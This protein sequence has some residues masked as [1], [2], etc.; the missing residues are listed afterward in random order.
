MNLRAILNLIM[1]LPLTTYA[2]D[3]GEKVVFKVPLNER[4]IIVTPDGYFPNQISIH[5][6]EKLR[7]YL[8][9]TLNTPTCL[10]IPQKN[11]FMGVAIKEVKET[12]VEFKEAG[13]Y[14][15]FCPTGKISGKITVLGK[16]IT[17][18]EKL[19]LDPGAKK[20]RPASVASSNDD[21]WMPRNE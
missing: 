10:M 20:R 1:I 19:G 13:T 18:E 11:I 17:E 8:T 5:E 4:A 7:I 9:S 2:L 15:F 3:Y 6:G 16:K 14:K 12:E 21:V